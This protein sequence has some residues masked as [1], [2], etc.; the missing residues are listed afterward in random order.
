MVSECE[1]CF[2]GIRAV[3]AVNVACRSCEGWNLARRVTPRNMLRSASCRNIE[4]RRCVFDTVI[5]FDMNA[6]SSRRMLPC[7]VVGIC[8]GCGRVVGFL[9]IASDG[10][11]RFEQI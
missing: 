3:Q 5:Y 6:I 2:Y 1:V 9:T 4:E 11:R 7:V 10:L 8:F